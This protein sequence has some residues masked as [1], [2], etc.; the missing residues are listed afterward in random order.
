[1]SPSEWIWMPHAA[2]LIVAASCQFRLAT[3]VNGV[4]VSTMGEYRQLYTQE[5][6]WQEIGH[7]RL[8]E[9]MVFKAIPTNRDECDACPYRCDFEAGEVDFDGYNTA[10]AAYAGHLA[11]CQKW[12]KGAEGVG[13]GRGAHEW[14]RTPPSRRGS[15]RAKQPDRRSHEMAYHWRDGWI[16]ERW[17][18]GSVHIHHERGNAPGREVV[19]P[20]LIIPPNEWASIV[21]EVSKQG[22]TADTY[23][24]AQT[25]HG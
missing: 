8:Y 16:F 10:G 15:G 4:I 1:M 19:N 22:G 2:H 23:Q 17:P 3:Y 6:R 21:A 18:D 12:A 20:T 9:T 5:G 13:R 11:L 14:T 7:N 24:Q 25:L